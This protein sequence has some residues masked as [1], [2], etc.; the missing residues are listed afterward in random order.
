MSQHDVKQSKSIYKPL[1]D[2]LKNSDE[3]CNSAKFLEA[4][5]VTETSS[6]VSSE[7]DNEWVDVPLLVNGTVMGKLS[8]DGSAKY[9]EYFETTHTFKVYDA[10]LGEE[11][12]ILLAEAETLSQQPVDTVKQPETVHQPPRLAE[13]LLHCFLSKEKRAEV[14]GDLV[15]EFDGIYTHLGK[16]S[17]QFFIWSQVIGSMGPFLKGLA[18]T[19]TVGKVLAWVQQLR[20]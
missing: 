9:R 15:E 18:W 12:A 7:A 13:L 1:S 4:S 3:R 5:R 6:H 17:A 10:E 20:G 16:R 19:V 2:G 8:F 11:R 14:I